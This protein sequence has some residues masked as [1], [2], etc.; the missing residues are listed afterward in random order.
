MEETRGTFAC[1][2]CGWPEPHHHTAAEIAER[3]LIEGARLA[4]EKEAREFMMGPIFKG[5]RTGHW[6]AYEAEL[7]RTH[8]PD[9]LGG[10][11]WA[12]RGAPSGPYLNEFVEVMWQFWRMAWRAAR[13]RSISASANEPTRDQRERHT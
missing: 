10:I 12:A 9:G 2:I 4:F 3:P 13:E 5:P 6:W 11:G 8:E 1:P 7:A